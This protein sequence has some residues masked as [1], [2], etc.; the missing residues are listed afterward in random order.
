MSCFWCIG[1]YRASSCCGRRAVYGWGIRA[2][3]PILHALERGADR[4]IAI[5]LNTLDLKKR[6]SFPASGELNQL[7]ARVLF[8]VDVFY[9]AE[10]IDDMR[11]ACYHYPR[12]E[13][14]AYVPTQPIGSLL[15]FQR[16]T[17]A[18]N[19]ERGRVESRLI[20][21]L[22]KELLLERGPVLGVKEES[23]W[24]IVFLVCLSVILLLSF[25]ARPFYQFLRKLWQRRA[26]RKVEELEA[27]DVELCK[28]VGRAS[29]SPLSG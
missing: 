20:N 6:A 29:H 28:A 12:A 19:L 3:L 10:F 9:D 23:L 2:N 4:V 25:I 1:S 21:D 11:T 17:I 16:E 7:R 5:L 27:D 8:F 22:C 14:L 13:I 26:A 15:D 18:T 24:L